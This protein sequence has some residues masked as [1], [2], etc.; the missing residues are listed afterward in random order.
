[1]HMHSHCKVLLIILLLFA[2][3][4]SAQDVNYA[5]TIPPAKNGTMELH[6]VIKNDRTY[7][8]GIILEDTPEY[9]LIETVDRGKISI[10]KHEILAIRRIGPGEYQNGQYTGDDFFSTRYFINTNGHPLQRREDHVYITIIG[11]LAEFYV[12][13]ELTFG[14]Q[15]SWLMTPIMASVKYTFKLREDLHLGLGSYGGFSSWPNNWETAFGAMPFAAITVGNRNNNFSFMGG[16]LV[17]GGDLANDIF[18]TVGSLG[19]HIRLSSKASFIFDSFY[20][21]KLEWRRIAITMTSVRFRTRKGNAFQFGFASFVEGS[22]AII[23]PIPLIGWYH[24]L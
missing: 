18:S 19:A 11:P 13:D 10:P 6:V 8:V 20:F 17:A 1:M 21:P 23:L 7:F 5:D 14:V 22:N 15:T 16:A 24:R 12:S 2:F 4:L 3:K 9:V